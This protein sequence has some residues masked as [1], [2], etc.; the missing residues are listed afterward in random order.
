MKLSTFGSLALTAALVVPCFAQ[1]AVAADFEQCARKT[2]AAVAPKGTVV[3]KTGTQGRLS[4]VG[5]QTN[6]ALPD[7]TVTGEAYV[8]AQT[9]KN[10]MT[11][12]AAQQ[13]AHRGKTV[14]PSYA[15]TVIYVTLANDL[16]KI[17]DVSPNVGGSAKEMTRIATRADRLRT[18][19]Q[20]CLSQE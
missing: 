3:D 17:I 12:V 4:V 19:M 16:S 11:F 14:N 7:G 5:L 20:K 15:N 6:P 1:K 8:I 2:I 18:G 13:P 9:D 10:T